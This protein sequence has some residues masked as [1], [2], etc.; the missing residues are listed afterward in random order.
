MMKYLKQ[1][2]SIS[3]I[4][5]QKASIKTIFSCNNQ[6]SIKLYELMANLL[7]LHLLVENKIIKQHQSNTTN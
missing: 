7:Q 2:T 1:K 4:Y 5:H 3:C 6:L